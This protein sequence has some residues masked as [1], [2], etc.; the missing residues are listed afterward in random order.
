[1]GFVTGGVDGRHQ[2]CPISCIVWRLIMRL[3]RAQ[4]VTALAEG[5]EQNG[6]RPVSPRTDTVRPSRCVLCQRVAPPLSLIHI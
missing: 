4:T 3:R 2:L 6:G 1:M 5:P